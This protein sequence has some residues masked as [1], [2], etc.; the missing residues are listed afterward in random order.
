MIKIV[1]TLIMLYQKPL[2]NVT[3]NKLIIDGF[4]S[5][6]SWLR[7]IMVQSWKIS[8]MWKCS[9]QCYNESFTCERGLLEET[10]DG[11]LLTHSVNPVAGLSSMPPLKPGKH[12]SWQK[13]V[14]ISSIQGLSNHIISV[15]NIIHE[16]HKVLHKNL[17][18]VHLKMNY[19]IYYPQ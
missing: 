5:S 2:L 11:P 7:F 4:Y 13:W 15:E 16:I 9:H 10:G 14:L 3:K 8:N 18:L 6:I 1:L 19:H 12:L 17:K